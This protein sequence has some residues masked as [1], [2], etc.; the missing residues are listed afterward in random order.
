MATAKCA[1]I[2]TNECVLAREKE[3]INEKKDIKKEYKDEKA[4]KNAVKELK[5]GEFQVFFEGDEGYE[6][7]IVDVRALE[8]ELNEELKY[9]KDE[10]EK[11]KKIALET[12][13]LNAKSASHG[14][15]S[16]SLDDD[17]FDSTDEFDTSE[18]MNS[19]EVYEESEGFYESDEPTEA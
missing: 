4:V 8:D 6:D 1:R 2:I 10:E 18:L 13:K 3:K 12:I 15:K 17:D 9:I 19:S 5:D 11:A 16:D 7:S 14:K